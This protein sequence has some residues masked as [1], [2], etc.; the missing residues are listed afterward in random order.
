MH[1]ERNEANR[2]KQGVEEGGDQS[3]QKLHAAPDVQGRQ[4]VRRAS[5]DTAAKLVGWPVQ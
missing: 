4:S 1:Q 5:N 2:I 3:G